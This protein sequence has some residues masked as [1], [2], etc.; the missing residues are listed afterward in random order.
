MRISD[1]SS[2]VCS[3]DLPTGI[4]YYTI[5]RNALH[6]VIALSP[7]L[8]ERKYVFAVPRARA[9]L[10]PRIDASLERLRADGELNDLYVEWIGN[11]D[12]H[13]SRPWPMTAA[14]LAALLALGFFGHLWWRR[15]RPPATTPAVGNAADQALLSTTPDSIAGAQPVFMLPTKPDLPTGRSRAAPPRV[16]CNSPDRGA[17]ALATVG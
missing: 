16:R 3:S 15:S 9:D 8:L 14:V 6:D 4:G 12:P 7:P 1:W 13:A 5:N 2:D 10:V 17:L 11:L